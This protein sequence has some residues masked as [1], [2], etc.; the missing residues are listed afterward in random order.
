MHVIHRNHF[1]FEFLKVTKRLLLLKMYLYTVYFA[2]HK[3]IQRDKGFT[4]K[5][6]D[7]FIYASMDKKSH[8]FKNFEDYFSNYWKDG[9]RLTM[10]FWG[11]LPLA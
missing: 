10:T 1:S 4:T 6:Q 5:I 2:N 8:Y 9:D 11:C 3:T 7:V